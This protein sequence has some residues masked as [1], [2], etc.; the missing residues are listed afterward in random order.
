MDAFFASVEQLTRPTLRGRPVLVG[1][2]GGRGRGGRRELRVT[3]V[4]RPVGHADAPG[5]PVDRRDGGGA[6][7]ARCGLRSRQPPGL[8][9][10]ARAWCPS[11]SSSP[12]MR[13]SGSRRNWSAHR[14]AMS[15]SSA[16]TCGDGCATRPAWSPRSAPARASRSPRSPRVWP[17]PT[18]S[19]WSAAPRSKPLLGGLAGAPA[20]GD[21]AGRRGEAAS[22][23]HRD[24]R[25]LAALTDAEVASILGATIG[26]ALHRLARGIDDRPVAERA[27][28]K[29]ISAE[30]TFAV[31]S[32]HAGRVARGDRP[33]RRARP[34]TTAAAT[35][36]APAPSRSS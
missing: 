20:V 12:S 7:A 9:H 31:G 24:D 2:L 26:P 14:R 15:S 13:R 1:G 18:A 29:Q 36:A 11:S 22:A 21:R 30:S 34:S 3:G 6:A 19:G 27:E 5:P 35:A 4:R 8:R 17:N 16:R 10:R 25:Q 23:G 33:D 28:A 32:D